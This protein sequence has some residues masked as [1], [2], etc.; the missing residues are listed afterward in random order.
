MNCEKTPSCC[1]STRLPTTECNLLVGG[2]AFRRQNAI[3]LSEDA[4]SDDR[5][6]SSRRRTRLPTT[7]CN[8]LVGG[9]A[10]RRQNAIFSSEH[11]SS[12]DRM[13]SSRRRTRFPTTEC[14]LLVGARAFRR[15][16]AIF[17][18]EDALSDDR[19]QSS[20]RRTRFPTTKC[21]LVVGARVFRRQNAIFSSDNALS[22][23]KPP[24]SR[25]RY[26]RRATEFGTLSEFQ[27]VTAR[28]LRSGCQ[29]S[30]FDAE[31]LHSSGFALN[32]TDIGPPGSHE[33]R[34]D[35]ALHKKGIAGA[36]RA[37]LQSR[38]A[39]CRGR[40]MT[41]QDLLCKAP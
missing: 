13:Q 21:N 5:M 40:S 27:S 18:S 10:F 34:P 12:D 36:H 32:G 8:L 15:Q 19:M 38:T 23:K 2:R 30:H 4:S 29:V 11:A 41:A 14:N 22:G 20:R 17:S 3:L 7:E 28:V 25:Q 39:S 26:I 9:R 16:N 1:R 31:V 33:F 6:Q 37:P 35:T 24:R